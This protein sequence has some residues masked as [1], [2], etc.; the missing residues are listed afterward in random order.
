MKNYQIMF[1]LFYICPYLLFGQSKAFNPPPSFKKPD[2][3]TTFYKPSTDQAFLIIDS[4]IGYH[5]GDYNHSRISMFTKNLHAEIAEELK[6]GNNLFEINFRGYSDGIP[7]KKT[8]LWQEVPISL[9]S[10]GKSG[11]IDDKDLAYIRSCLVRE[12]FQII[13]GLTFFPRTFLLEAIDEPDLIG[14]I[15]S[16]YRKVVVTAVFNK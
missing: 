7:N 14:K 4:L 15:G 13:S 2:K 8:K 5:P 9:C 6:N 1:P 16:Q 11:T 3:Q 12:R 10:Q